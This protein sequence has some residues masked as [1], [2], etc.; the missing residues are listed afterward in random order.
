MS[1]GPSDLFVIRL[2]K[3]GVVSL[4]C[5]NEYAT[6]WRNKRLAAIEVGFPPVSWRKPLQPYRH[7]LAP[8]GAA[9][10][11]VPIRVVA[12]CIRQSG[13]P[14]DEQALA[15]LPPLDIHLAECLVHDWMFFSHSAEGV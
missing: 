12:A 2:K 13:G 15:S 3:G 4:G 7:P 5:G 8:R 1:R 11:F 10:D 9:Y 14:A 6:T